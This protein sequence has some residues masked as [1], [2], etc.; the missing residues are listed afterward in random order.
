M[1]SRRVDRPKRIRSPYVVPMSAHSRILNWELIVSG[2]PDD[3][4]S[5][6]KKNDRP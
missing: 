1:N 3:F 6:E 4:A 5:A 2:W